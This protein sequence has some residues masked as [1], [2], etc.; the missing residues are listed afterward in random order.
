MR[1][2]HSRSSQ[3]IGYSYSA[4]N[5]HVD[6]GNWQQVERAIYRLPEW[7]TGQRAPRP[8]DP[9]ESWGAPSS[10]TRRPLRSTTSATLTQPRPA[11]RPTRLPAQHGVVLH[12]G[13]LPAQD[14]ERR[15]G[16]RATTPF[17]TLLDVAASDLELDQFARAVRRATEAPPPKRGY[18]VVPRNRAPLQHS[19]SNVRS[20][21]KGSYDR[22]NAREAV[23]AVEARLANRARATGVDLD[24]IRRRLGRWSPTCPFGGSP[25]GQV[26]SQG[27][28]GS[29]FVS[30]TRARATRGRD[31]A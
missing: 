6:R 18:F 3:G 29:N 13:E 25:T 21:S 4:Q 10:P 8:L 2:L 28:N 12:R 9:L 24:R 19:A 16:F 22:R 5:Y 31:V 17:R 1:L 15:E 11:H 30:A 27:W 23:Q 7:P 26:D 14:L 20:D